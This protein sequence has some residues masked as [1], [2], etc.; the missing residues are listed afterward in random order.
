MPPQTRGEKRRKGR[1]GSQEA[2]AADTAQDARVEE[3]ST[4]FTPGEITTT[5]HRLATA[6]PRH[7][8]AILATPR[9]W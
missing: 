9:H 3:G 6:L 5:L 8:T 4:I 2:K 1:R 7:C